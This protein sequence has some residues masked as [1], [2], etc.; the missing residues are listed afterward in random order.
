Y[1]SGELFGAAGRAVGVDTV[2]VERGAPGLRFDAGLV[3]SETDPGARL[4]FGKNIGRSTQVVFSQSLRESGGLTW[5]VSHA[6]RS[7]TELRAVSLDNGD[8]RYDFEHDLLFGKPPPRNTGTTA[9]APRVRAVQISGAGADENTL[10]SLLRLSPGD[11][12]SFFRW[13]DDRDRLEK[14]YHDRNRA[15]ARVTTRR[16]EGEGT[17][18]AEGTV[19][20]DYAIRP[21]PHTGIVIEGFTFPRHVLDALDTAW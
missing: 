19:D 14:F 3:A 16:I 5:I 1:L 18:A 4:T 21:G 8:R 9:P 7:Q 20:I 10:R 6:P 12:F 17:S 13:Q 15:E 2:R 11:R